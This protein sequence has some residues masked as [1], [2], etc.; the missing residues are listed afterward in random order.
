MYPDEEKQVLNGCMSNFKMHVVAGVL[1]LAQILTLLLAYI[2]FLL[3]Q[4]PNSSALKIRRFAL[5]SKE[6]NF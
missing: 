4:S 6:K 3:H 2:T 1:F 5:F